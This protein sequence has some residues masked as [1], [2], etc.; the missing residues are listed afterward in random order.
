MHL[1]AQEDEEAEEEEK[2]GLW[3]TQRLVVFLLRVGSYKR[4]DFLFGVVEL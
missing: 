4:N 1:A 2:D 3:N